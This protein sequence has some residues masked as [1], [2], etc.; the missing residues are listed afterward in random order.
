MDSCVDAV[1]ACLADSAAVCA[2]LAIRSRQLAS[3]WRFRGT[4]TQ[5]AS[6]LS[7]LFRDVEEVLDELGQ[8]VFENEGEE[9]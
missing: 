3:V 1:V 5:T 6:R 4:R 8:E 7:L 2:T 9:K